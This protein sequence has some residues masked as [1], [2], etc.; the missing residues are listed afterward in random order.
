MEIPEQTLLQDNKPQRPKLLT[1]ICILTYVG[2]GM[3][4][5]SS[6]VI[7]L[8]FDTFKLVA[9][10][11][12]KSLNL[13]EM[14]MLIDGP[15]I[16]F[17]ASALI[18]AGAIT[19]ALLMWQLRKLGFHIYTISQILLVIAPMYFFKLPGPGVMD[20]LMAGVFILL[21]SMNLKSMS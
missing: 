19:G 6:L 15:S 8:F 16:F 11:L 13:P 14:G 2:S 18:Y 4:V 12:S 17:A 20:I 10:N 5:I 21:Y 1:V 7:F 9:A 3:N